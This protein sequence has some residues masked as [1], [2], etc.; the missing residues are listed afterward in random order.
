M[1]AKMSVLEPIMSISPY[2]RSAMV[3]FPLLKQ[4]LFKEVLLIPDLPHA[5]PQTAL[6]QHFLVLNDALYATLKH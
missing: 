6:L 1:G 5:Y 3:W 2:L 4:K